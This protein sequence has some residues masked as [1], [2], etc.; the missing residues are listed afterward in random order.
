MNYFAMDPTY[1]PIVEG[2]DD[3]VGVDV[4]FICILC[5]LLSADYYVF[6]ACIFAA[7]HHALLNNRVADLSI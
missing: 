4:V 2:Q 6:S 1:S 7:I 5:L 3:V